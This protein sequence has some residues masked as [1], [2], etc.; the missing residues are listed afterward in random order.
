MIG[1][2]NGHVIPFKIIEHLQKIVCMKRVAE[3]TIDDSQ[4]IEEIQKHFNDAF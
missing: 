4:T 2:D 3:L 1:N